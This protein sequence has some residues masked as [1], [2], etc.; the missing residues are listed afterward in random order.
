MKYQFEFESE[1]KLEYDPDRKCLK[2][3]QRQGFIYYCEE[4]FGT[5]CEDCLISE[6]TECTYCNNCAHIS[7]GTKCEKC[8][9]VND[10][11]AIKK[12]RK[13][14][15]C[16]SSSLK[17]VRKKIRGLSDEFGDAVSQLAIGLEAIK[18]VAERYTDSVII[19]K[20]MRRDR[21]G[22]YPKIENSLLH[23]Q[24][25]FFSIVQRASDVLDKVTQQIKDDSQKLNI[26]PNISVNQ[27]PQITQTLKTIETHALS[28]SNLIKD[29]L[30]ELNLE[31]DDIDKK[32]EELKKYS[33]LFD[34]ASDKFEPEAHELKIAVFPN[35]KLSLP[36]YRRKKK[37]ILFVTNRKIYFL[38]SIN[39][40]VKIRGKVKAIPIAQIRDVENKRNSLFGDQLIINFP[41]NNK[42]KIKCKTEDINYLNF[43][44]K[45]LFNEYDN[46][47]TTDPYLIDDF[48][49]SLNYSTLQ[50]K[51]DHRIKDLKQIPFQPIGPTIQ[52]FSIPQSEES[53]DI[54]QI[55]IRLKAA[56]DTLRVLIDAF[57]DGSITPEE[58]FSRRYKAKQR[59]LYLEEELKTAIKESMKMSNLD[60]LVN[61][62]SQMRRDNQN[63]R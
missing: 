50:E 4:C 52:P 63:R 7:I 26:N 59:V 57:N 5:F 14:P 43:I 36:S 46:Y 61:F 39:M 48:R 24:N 44:F 2:C 34:E 54:K 21:Y 37:G 12:I 47:I 51:I 45:V 42:I 15:M 33:L 11:P 60:N 32:L 16:N 29:Y 6:K 1:I 53:E 31:L 22:L 8:G 27:L 40:G 38:P 58:Y 23:I 62:Y 35:I 28:Y 49:N 13:C 20:Q 18:A 41:A 30:E 25:T 10:F 9:K 3:N 19:A 55:K 17:D 56:K